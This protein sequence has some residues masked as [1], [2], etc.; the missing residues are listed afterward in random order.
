MLIE[1]GV[2]R[3]NRGF[4]LVELMV[5]MAAGLVLIGSVLAL[6]VANLQNN[7]ATAQNIRLTEE[8]RAL[9]E[10][11]T[12]EIRRARY[13]GNSVAQIG[14]G[15]ASTTFNA[16]SLANTNSCI[17]YAY[18]AD[19]DGAADSGEFRMI[20]RGAVSGRGVIRYGQFANAGAIDC[21]GGSVISSDDVN[22]TALTFTNATSRVD[23]SLT[24]SMAVD[25]STTST[26]QTTGSIMLRAGAF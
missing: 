7:S 3:C 5:G 9:T 20:A 10:I 18:D 21:S 4:S 12:R 23:F 1:H 26:R 17:R 6:V 19:G 24:L 15:A 13:N 2:P 14:S 8:S 22:V 16:L 25:G 11:F